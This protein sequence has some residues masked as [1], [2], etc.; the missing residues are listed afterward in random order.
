MENC[1]ENSRQTKQPGVPI[2]DSAATIIRIAKEL[3]LSRWNLRSE[4]ID[5]IEK[6]TTQPNERWKT[7][8]LI[9]FMT[10]I[11]FH[12]LNE[13]MSFYEYNILLTIYQILSLAHVSRAWI[14][15][16]W[17]WGTFPTFQN[18]TCLTNIW[19]MINN[20]ASIWLE[21]MLVYF[22]LQY[23]NF[24]SAHFHSTMALYNLE[25]HCLKIVSFSEQVM[26]TDKHPSLFSRKMKATV[27]LFSR[28]LVFSQAAFQLNV[29]NQTLCIT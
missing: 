7:K 26:S 23:M 22:S 6:K 18:C 3:I 24:Y 28:F 1:T 17:N 2:Y 20:M 25:L 9:L 16:S 29:S 8:L 19:S 21:N 4:T 12:P 5:M 13:T 10:K 27:Y 15:P 11:C 14:C